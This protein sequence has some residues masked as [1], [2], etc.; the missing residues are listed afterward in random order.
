V[1]H[2]A[3]IPPHPAHFL[4]Y[5]AAVAQ[6]P[7]R[8]MDADPVV[9]Q[10][11]A[12]GYLSGLYATPMINRGTLVLARIL[13]AMFWVT[14]PTTVAT[15]HAPALAELDT[16][17]RVVELYLANLRGAEQPKAVGDMDRLQ[18]GRFFAGRG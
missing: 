15:E 16:C 4:G 11:Y 8:C 1:T 13:P 7:P 2:P 18:L 17:R 12:K 5:D 9:R 6:H 10:A 14:E 3:N